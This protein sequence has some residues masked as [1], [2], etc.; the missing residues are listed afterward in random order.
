[1]RRHTFTAEVLA[2][3]AKAVAKKKEKPGTAS[4]GEVK[5]IPKPKNQ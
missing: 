2:A 4:T 3:N 1:M 5:K